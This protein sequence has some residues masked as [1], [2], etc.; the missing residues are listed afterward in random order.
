MSLFCPSLARKQMSEISA[1]PTGVGRYGLSCPPT[2]WAGLPSCLSSDSHLSFLPAPLNPILLLGMMM[3]CK[4]IKVA[5]YSKRPAG[6]QHVGSE[7]ARVGQQLPP[8]PP[9]SLCRSPRAKKGLTEALD[10]N[11]EWLPGYWKSQAAEYAE[12]CTFIPASSQP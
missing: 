5:L 6:P 1:F 10:G 7:G 11:T 3:M 2:Q 4:A 12:H 8:T 9:H